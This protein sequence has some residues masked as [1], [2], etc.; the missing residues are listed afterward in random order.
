MIIKKIIDKKDWKQFIKWTKS[1]RFLFNDDTFYTNLININND[2]K[3]SKSF[4]EFYYFN[5]IHLNNSYT[6]FEDHLSKEEILI[7]DKDPIIF[8]KKII[9]LEHSNLKNEWNSFF[10]F[11][12]KLIKY[13]ELEK[14]DSDIEFDLLQ[15]YGDFINKLVDDKIKNFNQWI[16]EINKHIYKKQKGF[17]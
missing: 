9:E 5:L 8:F 1:N 16:I 11:L 13:I 4:W 12:K 2:K 6:F 17:I 7:K 15:E 10:V 3:Y 14:K